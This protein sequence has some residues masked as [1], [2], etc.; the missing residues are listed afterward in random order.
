MDS[1]TPRERST[2]MSL[3]RSKDTRPE[4]IIRRLVH[5]LGYRFRLH[6]RDLP[7]TPDL[8]FPRLRR[9]VFVHG[10]FWH[11]HSCVNGNRMPRSRVAFWR[12]KLEG[13]TARDRLAVT[14]LRRMGWRVLTVWE[15]QMKSR[16]RLKNRLVRFLSA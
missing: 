14:R 2:L 7:G 16:E 11:Q 9:V 10:C 12:A 4:L 15:C 8:V 5:S 6:R 3:V 13:N 1:L